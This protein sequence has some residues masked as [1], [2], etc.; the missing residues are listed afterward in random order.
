MGGAR[1]R[2]PS[3]LPREGG[4]QAEGLGRPGSK[5]RAEAVSAVG[6]PAPAWCP[7]AWCWCWWVLV[8][9]GS[10]KLGQGICSALG[11]S[12][13][14][15]WVLRA[16]VKEQGAQMKLAMG[17]NPTRAV[18]PLSAH[19]HPSL[20]PRA[21]PLFIFLKMLLGNT[22][23]SLVH[24]RV[25]EKGSRAEEGKESFVRVFRL[26]GF[27]LAGQLWVRKC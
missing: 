15:K 23:F 7:R 9:S 27:S 17:P 20:V 2:F 13:K 10:P 18:L 6:N 5:T 26:F 11:S 4:N 24:R 3:T 14:A 12:R 19:F 22:F 16:T 21:L 8:S 25:S 1:P